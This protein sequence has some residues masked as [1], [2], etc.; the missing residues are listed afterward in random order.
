ML[1]ELSRKKLNEISQTDGIV[2]Q[3][4][5]IIRKNARVTDSDIEKLESLQMAYKN[6][7]L[8]KSPIQ[9]MLMAL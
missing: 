8:Q 6:R 7:N 9:Q 3:N 1:G 2:L 5:V 4:E